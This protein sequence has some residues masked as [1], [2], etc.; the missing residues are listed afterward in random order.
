MDQ[1]SAISQSKSE[2]KPTYSVVREQS[3]KL[4]DASKELSGDIKNLVPLLIETSAQMLY[5]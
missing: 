3:K 5:S 2:K 1:P 4:V